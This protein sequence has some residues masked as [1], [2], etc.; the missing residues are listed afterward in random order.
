[1]KHLILALFLCTS[2]FAQKKFTIIDSSTKAPISYA[3]INLNNGYGLYSGEEGSVTITDATVTEITVSSIGYR[4]KKTA[5]SAIADV[6][7][8]EPQPIE[9]QEVVVSKKKT[10]K[11][12]NSIKPKVHRDNQALFMSS[13]GIQ[14]AF[15]VD[16]D[17]KDAYLTKITLPLFR[18]AFEAEGRPATFDKVPFRTLVKIE[19]L[20]NDDGKPG[21]RIPGYE[22]VAIVQNNKDEPFEIMLT[23]E[24]P[25]EEN[26]MF[27]MITVLGKANPDGSLRSELGYL[28]SVN[29]D[30]S[31]QKWPQYCQPNFPLVERPKGVLTFVRE[32]FSNNSSWQTINEPHLHA[33]KKYPDFNIGFGYTTA[34]YE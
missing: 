18:V 23:E 15:L 34:T 6:L 29:P 5:I 27:V 9:L 10:K 4:D 7:A 28:T 1:M 21:E 25:V 8:L 30:G 22:Q 13:I 11:R 26:G 2:V 17:K 16:A 24:L 12:E 19:M 3:G 33:I 32:P 31:I 20:K 14:Y